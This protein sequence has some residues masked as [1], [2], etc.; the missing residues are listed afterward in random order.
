M[1]IASSSA[2]MRNITRRL[3]LSFTVYQDTAMDA[4]DELLPKSVVDTYSDTKRKRR[5]C[6]GDLRV[7]KIRH[8]L[9]SGFGVTRSKMQ[10]SFHE[11]FL[12][13]ILF[14]LEYN[15]FFSFSDRLPSIFCHFLFISYKQTSV[16]GGRERGLGA[17]EVAAGMG[18]H[19]QCCAVPDTAP[20]W[21]DVVW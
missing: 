1:A 6:L 9:D 8:M 12:A 7:E 10:I 16:L 13:G 21:Q 2:F 3:H 17:R 4:L 15:C 18:R 11:S 5:A 20:F 19:A 14:Y